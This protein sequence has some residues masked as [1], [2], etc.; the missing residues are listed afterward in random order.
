MVAGSHFLPKAPLLWVKWIPACAVTSRKWICCAWLVI[1]SERTNNHG[2]TLRRS[3]GQAA[4][5]RSL[6]D[7]S[8]NDR[9]TWSVHKKAR[10]HEAASCPLELPRRLS[11]HVSMRAPAA[12]STHVR[13]R[14]AFRCCLPDATGDTVP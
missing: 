3:S 4:T 1:A 8:E 13:A 9:R 10:L 6:M 12:V 2:D 11:P 5:Q 14:P 7:S